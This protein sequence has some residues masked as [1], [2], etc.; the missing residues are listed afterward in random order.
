[1]SAP[2][3]PK[4]PQYPQQPPQGYP[5]QGYPQQG[6]P[7]QQ[8][9]GGY[10]PQQNYPQQPPPAKKG[11]PIWAWLIIGIFAFTMLLVIGG[12]VAGYMF[13]NKAQ[14]MAKNPLATIA[15]VAAAANPDIDVLD[16]NEKT[17][18]ITIRDKKTG[19]TITIDGDAIKDGKI[20]IDSEEGHA[21]IGS[22]ANMKLPD[23]VFLPADAKVIGGMTG[24]AEKGAG[25]TVVFSSNE[26]LEK[27]KEFYEAKY[28]AAG[29]SQ[30][31]SA[32]TSSGEDQAL[33]L[34]YQHEDRKRNVTI[35][36]ARNKDGVNG[37][38]VYGEG[39]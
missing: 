21:E 4:Q 22:G 28:S 39:Q 6:H 24:N 19:K 3:Y 2:Q 32:M 34:V 17:G 20:T 7:P 13:F 33:Q 8:Q 37:S 16:V 30:T 25:G 35:G 31:T 1:M 9:Y 18:K 15:Q 11:L 10:P 5:Q 12:A 38:I 23:W 36:A 27:L 26:S 14:Q 29:Y